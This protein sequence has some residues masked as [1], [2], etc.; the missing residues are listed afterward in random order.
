MSHRACVSELR[1][2]RASLLFTAVQGPA[3]GRLTLDESADTFGGGVQRQWE[4]ERVGDFLEPRDDTLCLAYSP[5]AASGAP[6]KSPAEQIEELWED[7]DFYAAAPPAV[8]PCF[9]FLDHAS[10]SR[11]HRESVVLSGLTPTP[12]RPSL[13]PPFLLF[14]HPLAHDA[15]LAPPAADTHPHGRAER[16]LHPPRAFPFATSLAWAVFSAF[17]VAFAVALVFV[18]ELELAPRG[19]ALPTALP[20]DQQ[21]QPTP[22]HPSPLIETAPLRMLRAACRTLL[23]LPAGNLDPERTL[24]TI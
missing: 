21:L 18:V 10:T 4:W 8:I 19:P 11:S 3:V 5:P 6:A 2:P 20:G 13:A 16:R 14:L 7:D 23:P 1:I 12:H 24:R 22:A 15:A 9:L 17:R